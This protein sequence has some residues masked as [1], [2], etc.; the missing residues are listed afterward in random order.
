MLTGVVSHGR[1]EAIDADRVLGLYLNTL[2][3]RMKLSDGSWVDSDQR[4]VC[5]RARDV[6]VS[7]L[8]DGSIKIDSGGRQLFDTS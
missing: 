2:P 3:F 6:A 4:N 8:S 1:P 5:G 7:L